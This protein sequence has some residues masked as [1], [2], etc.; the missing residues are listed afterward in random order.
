MV[1]DTLLETVDLTKSFN[2]FTAVNKVNLR[3][4]R[5]SIH[6]LIGPNGGGKTTVFNLLTKFLTPTEGKILYRGEDITH[7]TPDKAARR[8]VVRSRFLPPS[9]T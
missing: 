7:E 4:K 5:G 3:V 6:A 1:P 2:G 9:R 8:G